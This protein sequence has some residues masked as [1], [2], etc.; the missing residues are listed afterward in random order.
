MMGPSILHY[1]QKP[2][3][4]LLVG[5]V[6]LSVSTLAQ[7]I[8]EE[9]IASILGKYTIVVDNSTSKILTGQ[10]ADAAVEGLAA[11]T[12]DA[13]DAIQSVTLQGGK[14][15]AL[16]IVLLAVDAESG[17]FIGFKT[18]DIPG[19]PE[20]RP[21]TRLLGVARSGDNGSVI[22]EFQEAEDTAHWKGVVSR[23]GIMKVER[24]E[25]LEVYNKEGELLDNQAASVIELRKDGGEFDVQEAAKEILPMLGT[26]ANVLGEDFLPAGNGAHRHFDCYC[27][28]IIA[29]MSTLVLGRGHGVFGL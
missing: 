6:L 20:Y 24:M 12:L 1:R 11:G 15:A 17:L 25:G 13:L 27:Y 26:R 28:P 3:L 29:L 8:S 19:V 21:K 2:A 9:E 18:A 10:L 16:D 4:V 5:V 7:T 14:N 23:E 22:M